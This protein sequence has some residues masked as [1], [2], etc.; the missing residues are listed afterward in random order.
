[1]QGI[2]HMIKDSFKANMPASGLS[3]QIP[4][5]TIIRSISFFIEKMLV[6]FRSNVTLSDQDEES[7]TEELLKYLSHHSKD[8]YFFFMKEVIQRPL[9]GR[10]R[11]VDIGAFLL[12]SDR[13]PIFTLEA[14]RLPTPSKIREK[15]YV[16]GTDSKKASGGIERYKRNLHGIDTENSAIIGYIQK[17]D[18]DYWAAKINSWI[19]ELSVIG[20]YSETDWSINDKLT[21]KVDILFNIIS[22]YQ[23]VNSRDYDGDIELTHYLVMM[24]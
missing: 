1:M 8:E 10:N 12:P 19:D 3:P 22:K 4:K 6:L 2:N 11:R 21:N 15:E 20:R 18:I 9:V 13:S 23:S 16:V 5:K 24:P 17:N 7:I 14:K